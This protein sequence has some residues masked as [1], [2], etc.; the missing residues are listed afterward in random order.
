MNIEEQILSQIVHNESF[1]RAVL[2]HVKKEYF[3]DRSAQTLF[4]VI[5]KF[6]T[7]YTSVPS[8]GALSVEVDKLEVDG[9]DHTDLEQLVATIKPKEPVDLAWIID[10][11]EEYCKERAMQLALREAITIQGDPERSNGEITKIMQ[12]ALGITFDSKVGHDFFEDAGAR[13]DD[14]HSVAS[15][16]P[17]D[18]EVLNQATQ[19][20]VEKATLNVIMAG[21]VHPETEVMARYTYADVERIRAISMVKLKSLIDENIEVDVWSPD[22]YVRVLEFVDKG[23]YQEYAI[24]TDNGLMLRC[25]A[26]HMVKTYYGWETAETLARMC[27]AK[28]CRINLETNDGPQSSI[29]VRY[30]TM[31]PIVDIVVDHENHRYY[32]NGIESHNTN[33]GKSLMMC[34]LAAADV[35]KGMNVLYITAEMSEKKISQRIDANLIDMPLDHYKDMPKQWFLDRIETIKKK[36]GGRII[37]KEYAGNA[38]HVGHIRHL[39][40]ELRQKKGFKP[41]V[42]YVDYINI[43]ACQRYKASGVPKHQYIQAIAEELR[44]LGQ[45]EDV[46]VWT[47][48]QTNRAGFGSSDPDITDVAEAWG[49]PHTADWFI[50]VIQPDDLAEMGQYLV[51]QEKS[52]YDDKN[53]MRKFI[54]GVDKTKMKLYDIDKQPNLSGG[55]YENEIPVFDNGAIAEADDFSSFRS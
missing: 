46:P 17:F 34:H 24:S 37:V 30:E 9:D 13:Y 23:L 32:A 10:Q 5:D 1:A 35:L 8:I 33:V 48:T 4:D 55:Q 20:G 25:N 3:A 47:A 19:G 14:L 45:T 50:I 2:P 18:L 38:A 29:V 28:T 16:I 43:M 44:S 51:K 49:L 31:I 53:K 11:T 15:K 54:I 21:C 36:C 39:L 27:E 22:G 26:D 52:R 7:K 6:T 12:D 40:Q 42:I 41:D